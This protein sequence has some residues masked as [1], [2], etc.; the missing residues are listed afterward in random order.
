MAPALRA[1]GRLDTL[2]Q[3]TA[4]GAED[5][6]AI[7]RQALGEH[8]LSDTI[9]EVCSVASPVWNEQSWKKPW[10]IAHIE[11]MRIVA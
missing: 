4:P 1:A 3:L 8:A 2:V 10:S 6:A 9:L 7:L 11:G 5:R